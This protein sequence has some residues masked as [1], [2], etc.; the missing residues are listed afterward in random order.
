MMLKPP[1]ENGEILTGN[2][3]YQGFCKDLAEEIARML[4]IQCKSLLY[5]N[6][7]VALGKS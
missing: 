6:C 2:D 1:E 5:D 7:Y 4:K 3:R